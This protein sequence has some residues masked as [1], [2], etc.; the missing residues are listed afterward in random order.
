MVRGRHRCYFVRDSS[1]GSPQLNVPLHARINERACLARRQ[2]SLNPET[3]LP[4]DTKAGFALIMTTVEPLHMHANF[5]V[6]SVLRTSA[7]T[8]RGSYSTHPWR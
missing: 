2:L 7:S 1:S 8:P 4:C 3:L 5:L 6:F